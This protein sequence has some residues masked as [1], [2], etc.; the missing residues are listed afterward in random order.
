MTSSRGEEIP[1]SVVWLYYKGG[2]A[3][4]ASFGGT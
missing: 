2:P 1:V 3:F 4:T